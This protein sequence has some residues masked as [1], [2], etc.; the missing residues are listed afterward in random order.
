[1]DLCLHPIYPLAVS[2]FQGFKGFYPF[3]VEFC[4]GCKKRI[5]SY[6]LYVKVRVSKHR[7]WKMVSFL[8]CVFLASLSKVRYLYGLIWG[9]CFSHLHLSAFLLTLCAFHTVSLGY[10]L[11]YSRLIP[12][13]V[14]FSVKIAPTILNF[15]SCHINFEILFSKSVKNGPGLLIDRIESTDCFGLDGHFHKINSS[16]S[17]AQ[18]IF[19][20]SNAFFTLSPVPCVSHWEI[21]H[22]L[23]KVL[24]LSV[25]FYYFIDGYC[26]W[27]CFF[28]FF[29]S[30]IVFGIG[31]SYWIW[32]SWVS[33]GSS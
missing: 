3:A 15:W 25:L 18:D 16:N 26:G 17:W 14:S 31:E 21:V 12:A 11:W 4:V 29:A 24:F 6:F 2:D 33:R 10:N 5:R 32:G 27:G 30:L 28:D 7:Y 20:S 9:L 13:G 8:Q 22:F 1:M 19:P 23:G